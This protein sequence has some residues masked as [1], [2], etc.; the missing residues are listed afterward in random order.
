LSDWPGLEPSVSQRM[1]T[2]CPTAAVEDNPEFRTLWDQ[3]IRPVWTAPFEGLLDRLLLLKRLLPRLG[4]PDGQLYR[5]DAVRKLVELQARLGSSPGA[6][7]LSPHEVSFLEW[8]AWWERGREGPA[9]KLHDSPFSSFC[10]TLEWGEPGRLEFLRKSQPKTEERFLLLRTWAAEESCRQMAAKER[11][12][13]VQEIARQHDLPHFALLAL[14]R[15]A[16]GAETLA[17]ISYR[18]YR[19]LRLRQQL[20]QMGLP[21]CKRWADEAETWLG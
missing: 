20:R 7:E 18:S 14:Q 3:L 5:Q 13:Q 12:T 16:P 17:R 10:Q 8:T 21:E 1:V 6:E 15:I 2:N 9:P 19:V 4:G 11:W